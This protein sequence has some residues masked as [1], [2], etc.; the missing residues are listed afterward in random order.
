MY[1][2]RTLCVFRLC[3]QRFVVKHIAE[4]I[5]FLGA[6]IYLIDKNTKVKIRARRNDRKQRCFVLDVFVA[7]V[8][9]AVLYFDI[10]HYGNSFVRSILVVLSEFA[11]F[12]LDV[13]VAR[14]CF[15]VLYFYIFH[16]GNSFVRSI[17]VVLSVVGSFQIHRDFCGESQTVDDFDNVVADLVADKRFKQSFHGFFRDLHLNAL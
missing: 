8:C 4:D 14:V 6:E 9:F 15:A 2:E 13:F 7:R 11:V 5:L 10:F 17:L 16:Y 1:A 12:V 3:P